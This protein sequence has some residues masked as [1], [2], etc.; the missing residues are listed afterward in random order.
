MPN[1]TLH[2]PRLILRAFQDDDVDPLFAIQGNQDAMQYTHAAQSRTE[3]AHWHRAYGALAS[4]LGFAPW[5]VVHRTQGRV[6]GWGGLSIDP[7]DPGWGVEVSYY[8]GPSYW[9]QGYATELV[10][11]ALQHGFDGLAMESIGA[12]VRPENRASARVLEKCGLTA[13]GYEPRLQRNRY[14][15]H[16]CTWRALAPTAP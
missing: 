13:L 14:A 12:F 8:F 4:T 3:C 11:S 10:R 16:G 1:A 15:I 5:T 6:I 2:T 7:F 9:G